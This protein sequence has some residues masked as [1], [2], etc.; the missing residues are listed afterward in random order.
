MPSFLTSCGS[1]GKYCLQIRCKL[2]VIYDMKEVEDIELLTII[3]SCELV[4][5]S[6]VT[7]A[8]WVVLVRYD[9]ASLITFYAAGDSF[10]ADIRRDIDP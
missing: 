10:I 6:D 7:S 5:S 3:L 1:T 4:T 8:A 2:A 9:K